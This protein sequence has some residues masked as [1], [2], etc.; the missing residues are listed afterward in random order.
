M[1]EITGELL[2]VVPHEISIVRE[3]AYE[4][5]KILG[6]GAEMAESRL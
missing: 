2:V 5:A 4:D 1:T 6:V 3:P